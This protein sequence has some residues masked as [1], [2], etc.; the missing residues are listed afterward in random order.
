MDGGDKHRWGSFLYEKNVASVLSELNVVDSN[1]LLLSEERDK[2]LA[3]DDAAGGGTG[4]EATAATD[5][6]GQPRAVKLQRTYSR[7]FFPGDKTR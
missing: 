1:I 5:N 6:S 3:A 7:G 4:E 2:L